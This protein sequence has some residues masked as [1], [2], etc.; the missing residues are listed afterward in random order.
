MKYYVDMYLNLTEDRSLPMHMGG[1]QEDIMRDVPQHKRFFALDYGGPLYI[2][3]Q[4]HTVGPATYVNG[5]GNHRGG[6]KCHS[7]HR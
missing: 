4:K 1:L 2:K 7:S 5:V 6:M 3:T